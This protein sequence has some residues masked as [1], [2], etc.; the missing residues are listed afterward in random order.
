MA[1]KRHTLCWH[2][3]HR[4]QQAARIDAAGD[5]VCI[6]FGFLHMSGDHSAS[7]AIHMRPRKGGVIHRHRAHEVVFI[8]IYCAA[9]DSG[10]ICVGVT[11]QAP[12]ANNSYGIEVHGRCVKACMDAIAD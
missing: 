9:L 6:A 5:Y 1:G 4:F 2:A 8:K 11:L 7:S 10:S 3:M 12:A